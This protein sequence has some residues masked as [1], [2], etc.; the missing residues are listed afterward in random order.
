MSKINNF[1]APKAIT[2]GPRGPDVEDLQPVLVLLCSAYLLLAA[3]CVIRRSP[4]AAA[5]SVAVRSSLALWRVPRTAQLIPA[6]GTKF[7]L[8]QD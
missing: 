7:H 4:Y 5:Q 2:S 1:W 6:P 8:S 3:G